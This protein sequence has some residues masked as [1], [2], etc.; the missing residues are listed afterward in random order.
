MHIV[1]GLEL[2]SYFEVGLIPTRW[3]RT[4]CVR[5]QF[6][7]GNSNIYLVRHWYIFT[8][9]TFNKVN[10]FDIQMM[11]VRRYNIAKTLMI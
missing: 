5:I 6:L 7:Q 1:S 9:R 10:K 11:K 3:S 8:A 2:Q 4:V